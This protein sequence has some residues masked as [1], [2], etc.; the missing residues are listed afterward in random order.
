MK[1]KLDAITVMQND[2]LKIREWCSNFLLLN[3]SKTKLMVFGSKQSRSK[4]DNFCLPFMGRDLVPKHTTKN[5]G[6]SLDSNFTYDEHVIKTVSSCMSH[7][8]QISRTRHAFD[9]RTLLTI[10]NTLVF[11]KLKNYKPFRTLR[12]AL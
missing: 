6:V 11:S 10:I 3:P 5:L 8:G 9:K 1:D 2:Q 12:A 4:L 7:L